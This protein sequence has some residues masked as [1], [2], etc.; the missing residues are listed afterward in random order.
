MSVDIKPGDAPENAVV[1]LAGPTAPY[2]PTDFRIGQLGEDNIIIPSAKHV[3]AV[4]EWEPEGPPRIG[5]R[6]KLRHSSIEGL[7]VRQ[8]QG[9]TCVL[10]EH[11]SWS[12]G[13]EGYQI[14]SYPAAGLIVT[15][16]AVHVP[17]EPK[18]KP[19]YVNAP[20]DKPQRGDEFFVGD[21]MWEVTNNDT[22]FHHRLCCGQ[23]TP[24]EGDR[25]LY[26]RGGRR[27]RG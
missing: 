19:F 17:V 24:P 18:P 7:V 25:E 2:N 1:V 5:D 27:W 8:Y 16:R 15:H 20:G 12:P 3:K 26:G 6:V 9:C 10:F 21:H 13:S 4:A 23:D 11:K 22:Y 14:A